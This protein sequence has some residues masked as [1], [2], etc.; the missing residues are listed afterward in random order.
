M[1]SK[2]QIKRPTNI[3]NE[4]QTWPN[5][6]NNHCGD[7]RVKLQINASVN[8][9]NTQ[10]QYK[11]QN[12]KHMIT[13]ERKSKLDAQGTPACHLVD[14]DWVA[15][16]PDGAEHRP[17]PLP[18]ALANGPLAAN[19]GRFGRGQLAKRGRAFLSLRALLHWFPL[20]RQRARP[21]R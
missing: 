3:L 6:T 10:A 19:A 2:T 9:L 15:T 4:K 12:Q 16:S 14:L 20:S 8:N 11:D 21:Q 5:K 7:A 1:Q 18:L 13:H 17:W